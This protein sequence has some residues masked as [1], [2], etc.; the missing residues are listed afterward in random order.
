MTNLLIENKD[1]YAY[2]V[3]I[4]EYYDESLAPALPYV[5]DN[6]EAFHKVLS[7]ETRL[8]LSNENISIALN[9]GKK[10]I[11]RKLSSLSEL[12]SKQL[13]TVIFYFSGISFLQA[14]YGHIYLIPSDASFK[15]VEDEGISLKS[16]HVKLKKVKSVRKIIILDLVQ[17]TNSNGGQTS[18]FD[19]L[20]FMDDVIVL[21]NRTHSGNYASGLFFTTQLLDILNNGLK[22]SNPVITISDIYKK[23]QQHAELKTTLKLYCPDNLLSTVVTANVAYA[24]DA[25]NEEE[26][27]WSLTMKQNTIQAFDQFIERFPRGKY[28]T[29]A[30]NLMRKLEEEEQ[31]WHEA[32]RK[33]LLSAF[34]EYLSLYPEGNFVNE[35]MFKIKRLKRG[36]SGNLVS[37]NTA[38]SN[39]DELMQESDNQPEE[40]VA[41]SQKSKFDDLISSFIKKEGSVSIRNS[42]I[43]ASREDLSAKAVEETDEIITE[44][45]AK[46]LIK[47]KQYAKALQAYKKLKV[48]FPDRSEEFEKII[49]EIRQMS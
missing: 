24:S 1:T 15:Y 16:L 7:D 42:K 23:L 20:D 8:A 22:N 45:F 43:Q 19:E 41:D 27:A 29:L 38:I 14:E 40:Y 17:F 5:S 37:E 6:L 46:L 18:F 2:L 28:L 9:S 11:N 48:R 36:R 30:I 47:Q 49:Q 39:T 32:C 12:L 34:R 3:G 44:S 35:A 21:I 10:Q 26:M 33:N 13:S 25:N 31:K 4:G